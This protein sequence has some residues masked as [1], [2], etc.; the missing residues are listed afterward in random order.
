MNHKVERQCQDSM[1]N[2]EGISSGGNGVDRMSA[3]MEGMVVSNMTRP[4][5]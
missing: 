1:N 4:L 5:D 3:V 2:K